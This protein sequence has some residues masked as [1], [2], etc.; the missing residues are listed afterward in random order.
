MRGPADCLTAP[1]LACQHL[2]VVCPCCLL[3]RAARQASIF[4]HGIFRNIVTLYGVSVSVAVMVLIVYAPFLQRIFG[5][6]TLPGIGWV[7]Q[8]GALAF[9]L[10][11]TEFTKR[12]VRDNPNGWWARNVAW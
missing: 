9:Y 12:Q 7:P 11:W 4:T 10:P 8:I 6:A 2:T 3:P 5:T 1:A